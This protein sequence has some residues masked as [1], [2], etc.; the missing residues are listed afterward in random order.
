MGVILVEMQHDGKDVAE[1][2]TKLLR[3]TD[4]FDFREWENEEVNLP[5]NPL[6]EDLEFGSYFRRLKKCQD[7]ETEAVNRS[8]AK[9]GLLLCEDCNDYSHI[10]GKKIVGFVVFP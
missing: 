10:N 3:R 1:F 2:R 9:M 7:C 8:K 4:A 6:H 5:E